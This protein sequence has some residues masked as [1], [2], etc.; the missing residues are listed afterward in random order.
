MQEEWLAEGKPLDVW[1]EQKIVSNLKYDVYKARPAEEH[2]TEISNAM[3][4]C[5]DVSKVIKMT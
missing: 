1:L 4:W 5:K 3:V 2:V